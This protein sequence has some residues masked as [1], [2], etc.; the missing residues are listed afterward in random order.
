MV[1]TGTE[2]EWRV[3]AVYLAHK[4]R[5]E[6]WMPPIPS[7]VYFHNKNKNKNNNIN[8]KCPLEVKKAKRIKYAIDAKAD[9]TDVEED[10]ELEL[11]AEPPSQER[12]EVETVG[13]TDT[14][15][16]AAP[17]VSNVNTARHPTSTKRSYG[18][19]SGPDENIVGVLTA[20]LKQNQDTIKQNEDNIKEEREQLMAVL[21]TISGAVTTAFNSGAF[22]AFNSTVLP[23]AALVRPVKKRKMGLGSLPILHPKKNNDYSSSS[24]DSN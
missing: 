5:D 12:S 2:K 14:A 7:I 8:S 3:L 9:L 11:E 4:I 6:Q 13:L 23:R 24:S 18:S 17:I 1:T 19:R 16:A 21:N 22:N 10:F 20:L 15:N